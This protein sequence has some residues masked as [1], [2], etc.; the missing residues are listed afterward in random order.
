MDKK[1]AF[2]VLMLALL[3]LPVL[4]FAVPVRASTGHPVLAAVDLV[5][6]KIVFANSNVS[7]IAGNTSVTKV[8]NG[9]QYEGRNFAIIFAVNDSNLV[10]FSG[11]QFDLYISKDGYSSIS[12]DDKLY[13]SGFSVSDL[14][15]APKEV[16]KTNALLKGGLGTFTIGTFELTNDV[17]G[18]NDTVKALVGPIPFDITA[19]YKYIKIFDGSSTLVAVSAQIVE[20][21][22]SFSLTPS[23]GAPCT[24]VTLT[25]V[26]LPSGVVY[27]L[28]YDETEYGAVNLTALIAQVTSDENGKVTYSWQIPDLKN[29]N[30]SPPY[31]I[32]ISINI[33]ENSSGN[34][35]GSVT[36]TEYQSYFTSITV[37]GNEQDTDFANNSLSV[38]VYTFSE[39]QLNG[40]Y[41]CVSCGEVTITVDGTTLATAPL[42][43]AGNFTA[44][45]EIPE[46]LSG[47]DHIVKVYDCSKTL[48]FNITVLPTLVVDPKAGPVNTTVT[49][50]AYGFDPSKIYY[51]YWEGTC[52]GETDRMIW[53]ANATVGE[54]GKFN[55]TV[56][57]NVPHAVGGSHE[58]EAW[59]DVDWAAVA[60]DY[61]YNYTCLYDD[62]LW[63]YGT[64]YAETPF[65]VTPTLYFTPDEF[66]A[67][68]GGIFY[69]KGT[70]LNPDVLYVLNIDNQAFVTP[71]NQLGNP[72]HTITC[73]ECGDLT[74]ELVK[75]GF[76]PGLHS[77]ALYG[78]NGQSDGYCGNYTIAAYA[79]FTVTTEGDLVVGDLMNYMNSSFSSLNAKLVAIEGD[80]ATVQTTLG[81]MQTSIN[82]LDAKVVALQGNMATVQT[83]LGQINGTVIAING[84]VATIKTDV[85]TIKADVSAVKA[86]T[87]TMKGF[88]PVDMT[89]VWI[90]VVLALIAA[91]ASIY[92]IVV[93]R[94]KIAA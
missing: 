47:G 88:L 48:T 57:F 63:D 68:E 62:A 53:I 83:I 7:I 76:R 29:N 35:V 41:F 79:T 67:D 2:S 39:V 3:V 85:G 23:K 38:N 84:N 72:V 34:P 92:S 18:N 65:Y 40:S 20:I 50:K 16:N 58:V 24:T 17:T 19:D 31:Y 90:A 43:S 54:D 46:S 27:N 77:G 51:I 36:F 6:D 55:V 12:S 15:L 80:I 8:D 87:T 26:A 71:S 56:T 52:M 45:F 42:N 69:L 1:K 30:Q 28:T 13:A 5:D 75:A 14:S 32:N 86:D 81:T 70:G 33:I 59:T 73:D 4:S 91:I 64:E 66:A 37:D 74:V 49:V 60:E 21:L 94:S 93:I 82:N 44:T 61:G 25:G 11:A 10:T 89:P 78:D 9:N 22:P